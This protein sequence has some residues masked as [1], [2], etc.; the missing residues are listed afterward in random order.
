MHTVVVPG[1]YSINLF[2]YL[3][4]QLFLFTLIY[5]TNVIFKGTPERSL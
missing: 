3:C 2:Y 1:Q 4:S 5:I